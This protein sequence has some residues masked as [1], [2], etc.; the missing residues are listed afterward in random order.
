LNK[1]INTTVTFHLSGVADGGGK[2]TTFG[3]SQGG[4]LKN[5]NN[6]LHDMIQNYS[7]GEILLNSTPVLLGLNNKHER[8]YETITLSTCVFGIKCVLFSE[9][10]INVSFKI[11]PC[12]C[13][14]I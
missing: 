8:K 12:K 9:I 6:S 11:Y 13:M 3:Y 5:K 1:E 7:S 2:L 4:K 10:K 14:N